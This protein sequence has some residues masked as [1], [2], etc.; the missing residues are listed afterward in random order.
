MHACSAFVVCQR[1]PAVI[2]NTGYKQLICA[3]TAQGM[4]LYDRFDMLNPLMVFAGHPDFHVHSGESAIIVPR[5]VT[6]LGRRQVAVVA[7][8]KHHTAVATTSCELFTWGSNR[9]GRLGYAAVDTQPTPR[10]YGFIICTQLNSLSFVLRQS[11][12]SACVCPCMPICLYL[13]V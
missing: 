5:A 11:S 12:T 9:D 8:A 1:M 4:T 10:K 3:L 6:G 2:V 13:G 7:V